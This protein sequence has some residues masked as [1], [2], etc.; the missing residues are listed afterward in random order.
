MIQSLFM[1]NTFRNIIITWRKEENLPEKKPFNEEKSFVKKMQFLFASL[2]TVNEKF[3]K[4]D[5]KFIKMIERSENL[6]DASVK[7]N[8]KTNK[9]FY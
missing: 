3:T 1:I 7:F 9:I 5:N 8:S 2:L 4:I 6:T